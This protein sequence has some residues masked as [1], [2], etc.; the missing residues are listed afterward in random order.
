MRHDDA[1]RDA[2]LTLNRVP[3]SIPTNERLNFHE[4]LN[5]RLPGRIINAR[6]I[7]YYQ[8]GPLK[9]TIDNTTR[10]DLKNPVYLMIN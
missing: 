5:A 3:L 10:R 1:K 7:G 6:I 4:T 2:R 8:N 9:F